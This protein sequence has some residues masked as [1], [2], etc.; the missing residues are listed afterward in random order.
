MWAYTLMLGA[1]EETFQQKTKR[2]KSA[3]VDG[4]HHAREMT[5]VS[6]TIYSMLHLLYRYE[7]GDR[8]TLDLLRSSAVVFVPIVNVDGVAQIDKW[9]ESTGKLYSVRKNRQ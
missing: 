6:Q 4:V 9:Y 1:S 7:A 8:A 3:L 2:R 5:T